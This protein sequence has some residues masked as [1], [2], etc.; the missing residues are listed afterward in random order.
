MLDIQFPQNV[1]IIHTLPV[2]TV[3]VMYENV[4]ASSVVTNPKLL[5][6]KKKRAAQQTTRK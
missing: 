1:K 5:R 6:P 3:E 2:Q 4:G